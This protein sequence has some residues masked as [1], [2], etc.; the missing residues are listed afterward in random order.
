MEHCIWRLMNKVF[1]KFILYSFIQ[2][3]RRNLVFLSICLLPCIKTI[4][5]FSNYSYLIFI[6]VLKIMFKSGPFMSVF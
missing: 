2:A 6:T 1:L 3:L 5:L 4:E